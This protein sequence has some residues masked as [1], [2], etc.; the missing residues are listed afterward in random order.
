MEEKPK[1]KRN[2]IVSYAYWLHVR[3]EPHKQRMI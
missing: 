2:A 3:V 1:I